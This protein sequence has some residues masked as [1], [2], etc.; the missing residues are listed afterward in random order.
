MSFVPSAMSNLLFISAHVWENPEKYVANNIA[1]RE[2][3]SK[4]QSIFSF[5]VFAFLT[6]GQKALR[7]ARGTISI[8]FVR[9]SVTGSA[10]GI[11]IP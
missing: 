2:D 3:L 7:K 10:S 11:R 1:I 5:D 4:S 9:P 6:R 8:S